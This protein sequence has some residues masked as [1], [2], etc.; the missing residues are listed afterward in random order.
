MTSNSYPFRYRAYAAAHGL[1]LEAMFRHDSKRHPCAP[2]LGFVLWM[3]ERWSEFDREHKRVGVP[4]GLW[5]K[6]GTS[7]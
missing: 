4:R 7:Q 2:G 5:K 3:G 6:E 1:S